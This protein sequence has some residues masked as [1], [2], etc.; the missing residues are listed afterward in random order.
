M[1]T[2]I[3]TLAIM[4]VSSTAALASDV[5]SD[6]RKLS[7]DAS[8]LE[9]LQRGHQKKTVQ[10]VVAPAP[11]LKPY[12]SVKKAKPG[13]LSWLTLQSDDAQ[14][15]ALQDANYRMGPNTAFESAGVLRR[16]ET[17]QSIGKAGSWVAF[18]KNGETVFLWGGLLERVAPRPKI[19]LED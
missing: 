2:I 8:Q 13:I 17:L 3:S 18:N 6:T 16:G 12:V 5:G 11:K 19:T 10:Q 9:G 15:T 14:Y 7:V 4:A 1:K